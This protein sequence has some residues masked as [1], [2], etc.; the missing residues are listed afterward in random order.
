VKSRNISDVVI[1]DEV[2]FSTNDFTVIAGPCAVENEKDLRITAEILAKNNIRIMR[3]G[4]NKLRTSPYDFQGLGDEG[5]RLLSSTAKEYGLYSLTEITSLKEIDMIAQYIDILLVG[6]R[7]MY[8]YQLLKE[9][10][11]INKPVVLKRGM[12]ATIKEW[13]LAA[14]YLK[15][16]GCQDVIL[17]ERGIRTFESTLRNTFD[18][19]SAIYV[20]QHYEYHVITD[21]S[22]ATGNAELIQ[23]LV[24]A[25][26][27]SGIQGTMIEIHPEPQRALSDG[28]QMLN[29]EQ[30]EGVVKSINALHTKRESP[31]NH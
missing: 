21:P 25:S 1:G 12:S 15:M 26:L 13:L 14:E 17:C 10:G 20:S 27:V 3:G 2:L 5:I 22:H 30:F 9:I 31:Q 28:E 8:N 6:T 16:S 23:P 18:L 24:L 11:G 7:N 19:A 29:F 4:V